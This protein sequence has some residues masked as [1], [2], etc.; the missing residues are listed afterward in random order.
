MDSR[1]IL[2]LG[3]A[4]AALLALSM[5]IVISKRARPIA[6]EVRAPIFGDRKAPI[7]V[8][9]FE[10]FK[11]HACHAFSEK[12]LPQLKLEYLFSEKIRLKLIP[13]GFL[14]GSKVLANAAL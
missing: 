2:V 13:L 12:I 4:I 6:I 9:L 11:C 1:K 3:T 10:D 14:N 5:I 8:V 7:E